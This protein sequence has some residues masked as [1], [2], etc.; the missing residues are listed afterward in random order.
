MRP[1]KKSKDSAA[2]R[3]SGRLVATPAPAG[4]IEGSRADV[5][6][7]AGMLADK[8]Q[9][10]QPLYRIHQRL[11]AVGFNLSRP[12]LTQLSQ[13]AIALLEPIYQAQLVSIKQ[14]RII[15]MDETPIKAGREVQGKMRSEEHTSEL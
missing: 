3:E 4:V 15:T 13:Q 14:S 2:I 12:W 11:T 5:S 7:L 10:H 1:S 8:Y 6:F 9:Y